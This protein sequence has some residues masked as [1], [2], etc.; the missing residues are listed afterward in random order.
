V[1]HDFR[2][3]VALQAVVVASGP[4]HGR[5]VVESLAVDTEDVD[6]ML[7]LREAERRQAQL[8]PVSH[9]CSS[10]V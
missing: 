8:V 7:A 4:G 10:D 6:V 3:L 1:G 9:R 5:E 2:P